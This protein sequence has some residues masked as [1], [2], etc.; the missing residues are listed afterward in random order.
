MSSTRD[1][2]LSHTAMLD[3][4]LRKAG[5]ETD[6]MVYE[7]MPHAFWAGIECPE[8]EDAL[9]AQ[10]ELSATQARV[11]HASHAK[12]PCDPPIPSGT[13]GEWL[14][15][16]ADRFPQSEALVMPWQDI[17]WTWAE[18]RQQVDRLARG[19]NDL[20]LV[21]GDRVGICAPNCVEWVLTQLATA[22]A[23]PSARLDQSRL[24]HP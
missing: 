11:M 23:W 13:I 9:Q 14:D 7:G 22:Q 19:L 12:G 20:G 6:L 16:A 4:A 1:Q 10:A 17:R 15:R 5:V 21:V 8:T 24:P 2:L 18:L 3:L